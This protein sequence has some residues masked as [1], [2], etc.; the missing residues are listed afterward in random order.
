MLVD[1]KLDDQD[2]SELVEAFKLNTTISILNLEGFFFGFFVKFVLLKKYT[3][4]YFQ[5]NGMSMDDCDIIA[6][7]LKTNSSLKTLLLYGSDFN[8]FL[9]KKQILIIFSN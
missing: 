7:M 4:I 9:K 2:I 8:I 5:D 1:K 3:Y 6:E